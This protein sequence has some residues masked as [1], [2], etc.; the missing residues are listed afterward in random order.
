MTVGVVLDDL[1]P[2]A[3]PAAQGGLGAVHEQIAGLVVQ[4]RLAGA[5]G[6]GGG[7]L[8]MGVVHVE[9]GPVDGVAGRAPVVMRLE[10]RHPFDPA[11]GRTGQDRPRLPVRASLGG[12]VVVGAVA[13]VPG[14]QLAGVVEAAAGAGQQLPA[15]VGRHVVR[16]RRA[17]GG[18]LARVGEQQSA[19]QSVGVGARVVAVDEGVLGLHAHDPAHGDHPVSFPR[20]GASAMTG[21]ARR[22]RPMTRAHSSGSEA[23]GSSADSATSA[24]RA[25]RR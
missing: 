6:L 5:E 23:P 20:A 19:G 21:S 22:P 10:G 18:R 24:C 4:N 13:R 11:R 3:A 15:G 12:Q 14:G 7:V 16:G 17:A 9:P 1:D 2:R 8:G 25:S